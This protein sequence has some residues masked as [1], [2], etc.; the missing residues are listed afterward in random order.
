[1]AHTI[2][3]P[4]EQ[5]LKIGNKEFE[6]S[7]RQ[8]EIASCPHYNGYQRRLT[9]M[10]YNLIDEK[11]KDATTHRERIIVFEY[12]HLDEELYRPITGKI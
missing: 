5:L 9:T 4:E 1:M 2:I 10:T 7:D 12:Q 11:S 8:F 6:I 3:Y